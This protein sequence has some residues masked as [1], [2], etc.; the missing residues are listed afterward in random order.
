MS[1]GNVR[2]CG[3]DR[4]IRCTKIVFGVGYRSIPRNEFLHCAGQLCRDRFVRQKSVAR[5]LND[6]CN[7]H[8]RVDWLPPLYTRE[9]AILIK[10]D[11]AL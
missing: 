11:H 2:P 4:I 7:G 1:T 5:M 3:L 8:S 10:R 9:A 6:D